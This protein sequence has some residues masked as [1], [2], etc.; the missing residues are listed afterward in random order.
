MN[1]EEG[2]IIRET[3]KQ[4]DLVRTSRAGDAFHYRWVARFCL[5]MIK[6]GSLITSVTIE[7]SKETEKP[8]ECVMDMAVYSAVDEEEYVDYYQMKHSEA[9]TDKHMTLGE[10]RNTVEGFSDRFKSHKDDDTNE[11]EKYYVV[12]NRRI[13][14]KLHSVVL[15]IAKS[16]DANKRIKDQ[17]I[18][19]TEL[20]EE[21]LREFCNNLILQGGEGNYEDQFYSLIGETGRLISGVD[22]TD[23]VNKLITMIQARVLP[24]D[25]S[26]ITRATV[27]NQ[28]GCSS[29]RVLYPAP[30]NFEKLDNA[31]VR[32]EYTRL[33]DAVKESEQTKIITATGGLGK[34]IF[35]GMLPDLLG[36]EY[37]T[38]IYDCFGNGTYRN[39]LKFR[40]RHQD[41]LVQ[42][43]NELADIGLCEPLIPTHTEP[44]WI[45]EAFWDR[46]S[47]AVA[48]FRKLHHNGRLVIV[49]D[50]ADN[51]EMAAE[52]HG[53]LA[54]AGDL[55][56]QG[57]PDGCTLVMLSRPERK[58][59]ATSWN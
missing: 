35:T 45:S 3:I 9:R 30:S 27:L 14:Q 29:E 48:R 37:L 10:L 4:S 46:L 16:Q 41:A 5:N 13:D 36:E 2:K 32:D 38:V 7:Q 34:S 15:R 49:V 22:S 8:G 20:G 43:A 59:L 23:I 18:R 17:L 12:T 50:A 42:I 44:G 40:H 54:F 33:A 52:I 1:R 56:Q 21:D 28:F 11:K 57:L 51:A 25:R 55:I 31:V 24:N 39:R 53:H 47:Y 19:Y 6:P 58:H 26:E